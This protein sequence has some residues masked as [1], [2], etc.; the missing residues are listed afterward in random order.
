[1][2]LREVLCPLP[3]DGGPAFPDL[4]PENAVTLD[5]PGELYQEIHIFT[6]LKGIS[7]LH[8]NYLYWFVEHL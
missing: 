8:K 2:G 4:S 1:M 3:K 5:C 6:V 7:L